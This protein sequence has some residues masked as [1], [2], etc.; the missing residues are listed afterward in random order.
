MLTS[1]LSPAA[2]RQRRYRRRLREG[3]FLAQVELKPDDIEALIVQGYLAH[4]DATDPTLAGAAVL[5][6]A[7]IVLSRYGH[8][9][10]GSHRLADA[11]RMRKLDDGECNPSRSKRIGALRLT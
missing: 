7:K 2:M 6:A 9:P 10:V 8:G 4:E 1:T 3:V 5:L 11:V